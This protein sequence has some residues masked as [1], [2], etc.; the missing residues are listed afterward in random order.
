M[1]EEYLDL[2]DISLIKFSQNGDEEAMG[3]MLD[4]YRRLVG[5]QTQKYDREN[6]DFRNLYDDLYQEGMLGLYKAV[7]SY[8]PN[9]NAQFITYATVC[10]SNYIKNA[11]QKI[12]GVNN[13]FFSDSIL[14]GEETIDNYSGVG[15]VNPE[16]LL[17]DKENVNQILKDIFDKISE[18]ENKVFELYLSGYDY[19]QI[20]DILGK[21]PKSVDNAIQRI[22]K[23][24]REVLSK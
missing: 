11:V 5:W 2:D 10:V 7:L 21:E 13:K 14:E 19:I 15:L 4:R 3:V 23:K 24:A 18:Y 12:Y 1:I 20:A 8:Q 9:K 17:V 16:D 6:I 22:R